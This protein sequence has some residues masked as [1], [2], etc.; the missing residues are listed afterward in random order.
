MQI[1]YLTLRHN[2]SKRLRNGVLNQVKKRFCY[3]AG[4][5]IE[6][7]LMRYQN[8]K[9]ILNGTSPFNYQFCH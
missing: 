2:F 4:I 6:Y 8:I 7:I 1:T 9:A 5:I 3:G